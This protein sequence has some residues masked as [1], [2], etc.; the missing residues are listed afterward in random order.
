[1]FIPVDPSFQASNIDIICFHLSSLVICHPKYGVEGCLGVT[2][3]VPSL[4][5]VGGPNGTYL[6]PWGGVE[7]LM[8]E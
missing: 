4:N 3:I 7:H 5:Q 6:P 8:S 1:M 2:Q